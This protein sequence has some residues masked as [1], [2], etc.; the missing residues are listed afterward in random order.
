LNTISLKTQ[1]GAA[2]FAILVLKDTTQNQ[3]STQ[4]LNLAQ[5]QNKDDQ[6]RGILCLGEIG[7]LRDLSAETKILDLILNNFNSK[8]DDIR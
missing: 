4:V 5:S 8:E 1:N 7:K 3:L 6:V 2:C